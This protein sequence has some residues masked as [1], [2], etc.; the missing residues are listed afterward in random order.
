MLA[1][2]V[3][4]LTASE[5]PPKQTQLSTFRCALF[6]SSR[7]LKDLAY[8][9]LSAWHAPPRFLS[10]WHGCPLPRWPSLVGLPKSECLL[11][12]G[13]GDFLYSSYHPRACPL[14]SVS[15]HL[16]TLSIRKAELML[17]HPASI[18]RAEPRAWHT[19]V[20]C[21]CPNRTTVTLQACDSCQ[22]HLLP[23]LKFTEGTQPGEGFP[24]SPLFTLCQRQQVWNSVRPHWWYNCYFID[25]IG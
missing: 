11:S 4:G 9:V 17:S 22:E 10:L 7:L 19:R 2:C 3:P 18:L 8:A 1:V 6:F 21:V 5:C 13:L 23:Q 16:W 25:S 24:S 20:Q 12:P 14:L 15:S